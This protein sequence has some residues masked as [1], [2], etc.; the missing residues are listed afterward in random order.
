M[1]QFDNSLLVVVMLVSL[2]CPPLATAILCGCTPDVL[3]NFVFCFFGWIPATVHVFY[4]LFV[5]Y[6]RQAKVDKGTKPIKD[7]PMV[8]SKRIQGVAWTQKAKSPASPTIA[9]I[10]EPATTPVV[11]RPNLVV[12]RPTSEPEPVREGVTA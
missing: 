2:I 11:E 4:L 1:P 6:D 9:A 3:L 5:A 12:E 10:V 8:F 7:A